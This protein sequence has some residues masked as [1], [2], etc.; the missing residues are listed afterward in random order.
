LS[1]EP[2]MEDLLSPGFPLSLLPALLPKDDLH[3]TLELP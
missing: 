3:P 2:A 1:L